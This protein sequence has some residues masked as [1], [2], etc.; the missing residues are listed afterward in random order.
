MNRRIKFNRARIAKL[1]R[2]FKEKKKLP[3]WAVNIRVSKGTLFIDGHEVVPSEEIDAWL[4]ARI[5]GTKPISLSRDSGFTDYISRE[6]LGISRRHWWRFLSSQDI[7]QRLSARPFMPKQAGE[8]L[9]SRGIC[10]CDLVEV[11]SKDVP[12]RTTDTYIFTLIDRLTSFLVAKRVDTKQ[13][14][15]KTK[16]GTL[17]VL[18]ELVLEME[19]ALGTKIKVLE[20]DAGGEFMGAILPWLKQK[21]I[22]KKIVPL[23]AAIESRNGLLQRKIY[24]LIRT[25][26]KGGFDKILAEAIFLCNN[27][28]SRIHGHRPADVLALKDSEIAPKFNKK[29]Q[30]ATKR[31]PKIKKGDWVM[32]L[33]HAKKADLFFKSYRDHWSEPKQVTKIGRGGYTVGGKMYPRTRLKKV[34]G[35]ADKQSKALLE[36]RK[37]PKKPS[38]EQRLTRA[39]AAKKEREREKAKYTAQPR[40]STRKKRE[41]QRYVP[42]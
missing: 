4:R 14:S 34:K 36:S 12:S 2:D 7:H 22:R 16:R 32:V 21:G 38:L 23:G 9:R 40:Q 17:I 20:S 19:T 1:I 24:P 29:R 18:K 25:G 28:T 37:A 11:K 26:R 6:T 8:H 5:Y 41:I 3:A 39:A 42:T 30:T 10:Q 35:P 15:P 13:V 31:A 33:D 27:T